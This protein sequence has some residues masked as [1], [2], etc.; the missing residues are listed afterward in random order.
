MNEHTGTANN[1]LSEDSYDHVD[2]IQPD[3]IYEHAGLRIGKM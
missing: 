3:V 2:V 1:I